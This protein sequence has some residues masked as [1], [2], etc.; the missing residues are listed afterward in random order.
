MAVRGRGRLTVG[1]WRAI[2]FTEQALGHSIGGIGMH[3]FTGTR[4]HRRLPRRR[5]PRPLILVLAGLL[6]PGLALAAAG[7]LDPAF[8]TQGIATALITHDEFGHA[9]AVAPDGS[10]YVG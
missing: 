7:G 5:S 2:S 10:T 3:M 8:G 1:R 9:I 6:L 4:R